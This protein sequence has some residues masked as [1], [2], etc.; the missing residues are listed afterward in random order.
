MSRIVIVDID[1][2]IANVNKALK[3]KGYRTDGTVANN[4]EW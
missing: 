1:N 4:N 2:C 3:D